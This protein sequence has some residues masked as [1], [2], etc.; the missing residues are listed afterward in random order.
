MAG[1]V[2]EA[3]RDRFRRELTS[4]MRVRRSAVDDR[5]SGQASAPALDPAEADAG[6]LT[7][8][9]VSAG[10]GREDAVRDVSLTVNVGECVGIL[11]HNGAGKTTLLRAIAGLLPVRRGTVQYRGTSIQRWSA[12]R[13]VQNGIVLVPQGRALFPEMS[14]QDNITL[15]AYRRSVAEAEQSWQELSTKWPW[16]SRRRKE[17]VGR[18]SGG[19]QQLVA[20]ARGLAA[21]PTL[22]MVDEPSVGLAGVA[23]ADLSTLLQEMRG[24]GQTILL[25]EQNLGLAM[26]VCD[27]FVV[28]REGAVIGEYDHGS[29]PADGLWS[30]F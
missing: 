9:S 7:V 12:P 20:N 1:R 8:E 11:G 10:Y 6:L 13:R 18:L 16:L 25:V 22:L 3:G 23:V 30:L 21:R 27:R 26:S 29:L 19:Q 14:I 2:G 24:E 15:G 4:T 5:R 17:M 28:L